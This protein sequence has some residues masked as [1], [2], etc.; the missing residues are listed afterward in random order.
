[1]KNLLLA[2]VVFSIPLAIAVQVSIALALLVL[3]IGAFGYGVWRR[4]RP[5]LGICA[6][7]GLWAVLAV[8]NTPTCVYPRYMQC[9]STLTQISLALYQY[10]QHN[11]AFPPAYVADQ[12]GV[13]MHSWRVL[14]LP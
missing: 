12:N 1:M 10:E 13:P 11:G 5:T 4:S 9:R 7:I 6:A 2:F 3:W 14:I 8:M